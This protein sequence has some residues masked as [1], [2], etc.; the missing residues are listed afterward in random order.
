[1]HASCACIDCQQYPPTHPRTHTTL[2]LP[3][4]CV[5]QVHLS[6]LLSVAD[7]PPGELLSELAGLAAAKEVGVDL[8][9]DWALVWRLERQPE[10]WQQLVDDMYSRLDKVRR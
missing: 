8:G 4:A 3:G 9:R 2:V 6:V 10:A 1:M 5:H 7:R